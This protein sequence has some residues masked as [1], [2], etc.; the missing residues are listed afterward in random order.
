MDILLLDT[1]SPD[2]AIVVARYAHSTVIQALPL[3]GEFN[4]LL[5]N[6]DLL[7]KTVSGEIEA[8]TTNQLRDYGRQIF[9]Y[10][11]KDDLLDVFQH[12][13][14]KE[15]ITIHILSTHPQL[16]R[17]P[18]E[19]MCNPKGV[20]QGP[21]SMR[22]V[23]RVLATRN[24]PPALIDL[25]KRKLKILFAAASP[26]DQGQVNTY[27]ALSAIQTAYTD[28]LGDKVD[29]QIVDATTTRKLNDAVNSGSFDVFHF[30]GHGAVKDGVGGLFLINGAIEDSKS[31]FYPAHVLATLLQRAQIKLA[32][33]GACNTSSPL[34]NNDFDLTAA[35]LLQSGI[36][37]VIANQMPITDQ[38]IPFFMRPLYEL[39][40]Q[41]KSIDEAV[42]AGR[43]AL[44]SEFNTGTDNA[45]VEWG[46]PTLYR[47][48]GT[49]RLI[50]K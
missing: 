30:S 31:Q 29:L 41:G 13:P 32:V 28:H 6:R 19:F 43:I 14:E 12:L 20:L 45:I 11:M 1:K 47:L 40:L 22:R 35:A 46:I 49:E 42:M 39:L 17:I 33:L 5:R 44:Y 48:Q 27:G 7:E 2:E 38:S 21:N 10:L 50:K 34:V 23:A 24:S 25:R 9:S 15:P 8:W 4:E 37:A 18:W 3:N 16:R 26:I 36:A